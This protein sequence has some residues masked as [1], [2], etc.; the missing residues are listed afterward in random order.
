MEWLTE[1]PFWVIIGLVF[2]AVCSIILAFNGGGKIFGIAAGAFVACAIATFIIEQSIETD[3]EA[4]TAAV[5]NLADAVERNDLDDAI[6]F[7]DPDQEQVIQRVRAEMPTYE[8]RGCNVSAFR[9]LTINE[10]GTALVDFVVTVSVNARRMGYD[11]PV[12]RREVVLK[13]R[14]TA[15]GWKVYD[16]RHFDPADRPRQL[17]L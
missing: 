4:V 9:G 1:D 16:Y 2:V 3:R 17:G 14:Q 11:V 5:Y 7:L 13:F 12:A 10:D 6:S 15:A 8:F